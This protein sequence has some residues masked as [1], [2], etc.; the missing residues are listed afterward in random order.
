MI[1]LIDI[2]SKLPNLALMKLSSYYKGIGEDIEFVKD[3][4]YKKIYASCVFTKNKPICDNLKELYGDKIDI[5]GTGYDIKGML[6]YNIEMQKPDYSLYN[7]DYGI[8]FTTRGCVNSCAFCFV[9]KK[10]GKLH[11][12]GTIQELINPMSNLIVLLDNNFTA[13]PFMID[14]CKEI[15]DRKLKVDITQGVNI[16]GMTEDK[17]YWLGQIKHNGY[18]HIAWDNIGEEKA[19]IEGTSILTKYIKPYR[20]ICFVLVGFNTTLEEDLY[21]INK[22]QDMGLKPFIMVYNQKDDKTLHHLS[23]W[24]NRPWFRNSCKFEEFL[25]YVRYK[26]KRCL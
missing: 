18:L 5:G 4:E 16:R 3:G 1:G 22:L 14:K 9:P 25:P 21:R 12:V 6:P 19:V 2:D 15:K 24:C 13:D 26:N 8:G 11:Q 23:R 20:I 10:E 7:I 17:A